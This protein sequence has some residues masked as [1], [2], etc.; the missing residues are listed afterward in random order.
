MTDTSRAL[1]PV[2]TFL[3]QYEP[4]SQMLAA[5]QEYLAMYLEQVFYAENNDIVLPQD[6]VADCLYIIKNGCVSGEEDLR[7]K[8][9]PGHCFPISALLNKRAVNFQHRAIKSTICYRL[10]RSHFEYLMQQSIIFHDFI[11]KQ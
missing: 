2:L 9:Q 5:H 1:K 8:L 3:Q 4:F 6:G 10:T 7:E 11:L